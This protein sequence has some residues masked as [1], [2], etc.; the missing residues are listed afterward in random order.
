MRAILDIDGT[1]VDSN[2]HHALSWFRALRDHGY[3]VP[4]WRVHRAIGLGGHDL[5]HVAGD[6]AEE[7]AGDAVRESEGKHYFA[8]IDEVQPLEGSRDLV[9]ALKQ[10]E[11]AVVMASSAKA[12]EVEHYLTLLGAH[13]LVDAWTSAGDVEQAKPAPDLVQV[14]LE[15]AEGEE[16]AILIGDSIWDIEAAKR[17]KVPTLGVLTGGYSE[18]ELL[19]AGAQAVFGSVRELL[20]RL[21]E[22]PLG[23]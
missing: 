14:A 1:L 12:E 10:A 21:G 2:Y 4:I 11:H 22:T 13:E 3:V 18:A 17:A 19:D 8:L 7:R 23:R 16:D 5:A 20:D 15:K 6:E 9:L